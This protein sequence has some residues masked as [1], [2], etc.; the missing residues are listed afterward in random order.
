MFVL[1]FSRLREYYA[2]EHAAFTIHDGSRKLSEALAKINI[3]MTKMIARNLCA[4]LISSQ[5]AFRSL[6]ITDPERAASGAKQLQVL[7]GY[8]DYELVEMLRRRKLK[9][10]DKIMEIFSTHPNITKRLRR[11]E[12]LKLR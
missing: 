12:Q 10:S 7:T 3:Y 1:A 11:L 5:L 8:P 4:V 9:L 2:D 6:L